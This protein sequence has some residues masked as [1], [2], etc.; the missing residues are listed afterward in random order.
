[1][2]KR[3]TGSTYNW[4]IFDNKRNT[5][6]VIDDRLRANTN[7]AEQTGSSTHILDFVSNGFKIRSS[8]SA[9]GGGDDPYIYMAFAEAPFVNSKGVPA[10][11]R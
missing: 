2:I 7:D 1:M 6:N 4:M 11:A 8:N 10:N 9:I 5:F 3:T